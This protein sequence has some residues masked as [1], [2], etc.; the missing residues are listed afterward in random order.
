MRGAGV[1]AARQGGPGPAAGRRQPRPEAAAPGFPVPAPRVPGPLP[2]GPLAHGP[3]V[4]RQRVPESSTR[5][6]GQRHP[7]RAGGAA[8]GRP[9]RPQLRLVKP[10]GAE[11]SREPAPLTGPEP[12]RLPAAG[13]PGG[14][15]VAAHAH[16]AGLPRPADLLRE[17]GHPRQPGL[18]RQAG[19]LRQPGHPRPAV[20]A[21]YP[22]Q[23]GQPGS[24]VWRGGVRL[25]R[26]GRIVLTAFLVCL[27][28]VAVGLTA[29]ARA[30]AASSGTSAGALDRSMTRVVVQPGQT[31]WSIAVK[32]APAED[33]RAVMQ[34]IVDVNALRGTTLQP[35]QL[36]WVPKG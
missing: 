22:A 34:R 36:L 18:P 1:S 16:E 5:I 29:A 27:A 23:A 21:R 32:A 14:T 24:A 31:L 12:E 11:E 19:H 30:Q 8:G 33:P 10:A 3:R 7:S 13:R 20:H 35:G 26:R 28:L 17:A 4:P 25:T 2:P 15:R 9:G 6:G